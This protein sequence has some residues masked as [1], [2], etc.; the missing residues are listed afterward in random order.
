[1]IIAGTHSGCGKTTVTLGL[2]A[3]LTRRGTPVQPFKCGPDFIDPTL[4]QLVTGRHSPN[5]DL[6]MTGPDYVRQAFQRH[7]RPGDLGLVEGVMGMF[8]GGESSAA[9]LASCLKLPVVLVL[10]AKAAAESA[11]AVLKGFELFAPEIAPTAVI[12]NRV[13]SERHR[14][15]LYLAIEQ[16]CQ[17]EIIGDLP[18][19]LEFT[20]P[21]RHLGLQM[22]SE[23][24]LSPAALEKLATAIEQH[25]DMDR[26]LT[27]AADKQKGKLGSDTNFVEG[28]WGQTPIS[29]KGAD[30]RS[31]ESKDPT[32]PVEGRSSIPFR[33]FSADIL[34]A[35]EASAARQQTNPRKGTDEPP[36]DYPWK[37]SP[38]VRL[39]VARDAAFCFY[40]L[41]NLELLQDAGAELVFFSP[42]TDR[43]LPPDLDGIYLGGGYPELYARE[44]AA[45]RE[46]CTNIRGFAETGGAIY[47]E[48]GGF[49]YLCR[50]IED[51]DG[52]FHPLAGVFPVRANMGRRLAAL[53]YR[54][55]VTAQSG[56]F[57]P[58]GT[59]LRGHEFH[60][61]RI[62][63]MPEHIERLY[64]STNLDGD[65]GSAAY[66]RHNTV[67]G[68][69]HLHLGSNPEAAAAFV[70]NCQDN[71]P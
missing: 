20:I 43:K 2:L 37:F 18:R 38:P 68:Y 33:S 50:G 9:A 5:L 52:N 16:H 10:D 23:S 62:E 51:F 27:L 41:D 28:N 48:C 66:R 26:L 17:S 13:G 61:S 65:A 19:D 44:L 49:M 34:S 3:A 45:N 24:P 7:C 22:G 60:Y 32:K 6:W 40:Y 30:Q 63:P 71:K 36:G 47:G 1:M 42:L 59:R 12:L 58:A 31:E 25:V 57:G 29:P 14:R 46:I 54:E 70:K 8:D 56:L 35:S 4:H 55:A 69:L 64:H 67:A 11:A 39:G 15:R 53:G 21:E